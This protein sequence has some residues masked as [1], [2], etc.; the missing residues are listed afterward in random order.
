MELLVVKIVALLRPLASI[1]Y[2]APIFEALGV[3]LFGL[4]VVG[5]LIKGAVQK[6]LRLSGVDA[7]IITFVIWCVATS[8]IYSDAVRVGEVA[9]LLLPLLGYTVVKNVVPDRADYRRMLWWGLV[10]LSVPMVISA[11]LIISNST[12]AVDM[13]NY[14]TQVTR[15]KGTYTHS[16]VLGHSATLTLMAVSAYVVLGSGNQYG[17]RSFTSETVL[18]VSL[19]LVSLYCLYMSQVRSAILG[20]I[21]FGVTYFFFQSRKVLLLGGVALAAIA[22]MTFSYWYSA[23]LPE[24][25]TAE[26]GIEVKA[27]HW[28]SGRPSFWLNDLRIYG[29]L[30]LDQQL[31]GVGIGA[32]GEYSVTDQE[33]IGHSD[34][35]ELLTQTGA[36]GFLLFAVLQ[37]LILKKIMRLSGRERYVFFGLFIAVNFMMVLSNSYV[38]RIQVSQLYYMMLAFI[39]IPTS[40]VVVRASDQR[41]GRVSPA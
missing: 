14:W 30:P 9:K 29:R 36:V 13:V 17:K 6:T 22:V 34:W 26:R 32:R 37:I 2:A 1:E 16:H 15:W 10:G 11:V 25:V 21:M 5:L 8:I 31:G 19:G 27:T 41:A 18:L 24:A 28:G 33:I 4:L 20:L 35:L 40:T 23:L 39:E 38:W 12:I 7:V 3:A